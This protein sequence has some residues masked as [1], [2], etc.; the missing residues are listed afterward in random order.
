VFTAVVALLFYA[1]DKQL[2]I[3][4][5]LVMPVLI[6]E[7]LASGEYRQV[8]AVLVLAGAMRFVAVSVSDE[9]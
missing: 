8:F 2:A 7:D 5:A 9:V 1:V 3:I 6:A 4:I